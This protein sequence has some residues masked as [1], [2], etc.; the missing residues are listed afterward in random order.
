MYY[1]FNPNLRKESAQRYTTPFLWT[2]F[3]LA[4][5]PN[6]DTGKYLGL[7]MS[8]AVVKQTNKKS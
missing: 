8:R 4:E 2:S 6:A 1:R 7:E 5:C 3:F